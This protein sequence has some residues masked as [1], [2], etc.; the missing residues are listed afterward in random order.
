MY[1]NT[2]LYHFGLNPENF[3]NELVEPHISDNG[4]I[5]YNLR[6]RIDQ[7][8]CPTCGCIH[9]EI[10]NYYW[11]ETNFTTND[12]NPVLIRI[13]KV[14]FKCK[15]CGKTFTP[16][17]TGIE[18]YSRISKQV[19]SLIVN[20]F[21]KQ[22]SFTIIAADYGLTKSEI[23]KLFD[24]HFPYVGKG[25]LPTALC[26][27]EIGFKT[28]DGNYAAILYDHDKRIVTDIIRNRQEDYLRSYFYGYSFKER[29]KVKYFISD[30]YEGYAT[31][32]DEFFRDAIHIADMFHVIRLLKVVISKLRVN[33]YK[34]F[35]DEGDVTRHFMKQHWECFEQYLDNKLAYKPYYSKKERFEYTTWQMMRRCLE[36]NQTFWDAYSC[37][38]DFYEYWRCTSFEQAIKHIE[39]IVNKLK[40]TENDDLIR[41]ANT[42]YKWRYE[43][44][45]AI[46]I[47]NENGKRYSNG[48][49]EGMNNAIK[50]IIKDANGYKN[51]ER[52]RKRVLLILRDKKNLSFKCTRGLHF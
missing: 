15:T 37:L 38:Q 34:Q 14:R 46:T 28:E 35:T 1:L 5:I 23:E 8:T 20:E 29:S 7:R 24:K 48:P 32:K 17:I 27:D 50:T 52:F 33:T 21:Y 6:Q 22:K 11:T 40:R 9:A 30:L 44:A 49:A 36:L 2:F 25:S 18:R 43:I 26:I 41:V 45:N 10:N 12:G 3:I 39:L 47:K 16:N 19:E 4:S 42:Y 31:I 51:F 13:K